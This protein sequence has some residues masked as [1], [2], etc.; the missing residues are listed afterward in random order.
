MKTTKEINSGEIWSGTVGKLVLM[1]TDEYWQKHRNTYIK[2]G[3]TLTGN[4]RGTNV[5]VAV[6]A[7]P[8]TLT[9]RI[10]HFGSCSMSVSPVNLDFG[11]L[12]PIDI[13]KGAVYKPVAVTEL[14]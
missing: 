8:A 12:S 6:T 3:F 1:L 9:H 4:V 13:N 7:N 14:R 5:N 11:T 2:F 10:Q